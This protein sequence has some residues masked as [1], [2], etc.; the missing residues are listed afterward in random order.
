MYTNACVESDECCTAVQSQ[1]AV[2]AYFTNKHPLPFVFAKQWTLFREK[3]LQ[4][5]GRNTTGHQSA[6][7]QSQKVVYVYL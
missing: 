2:A 6:G 3:N 4:L 1:K 7:L 5:Q